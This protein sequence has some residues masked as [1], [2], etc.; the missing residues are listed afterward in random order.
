PAP[1]GARDGAPPSAAAAASSS[2]PGDALTRDTPFS[3]SEI[4]RQPRTIPAQYASL[5][6]RRS[7]WP[8]PE[9]YVPPAQRAQVPT[10]VP[11][12]TPDSSTNG[13]NAP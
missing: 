13:N 3:A 10:R 7:F 1:S 5:P 4:G 12:G 9:A 11:P 2:I 6:T 8:A